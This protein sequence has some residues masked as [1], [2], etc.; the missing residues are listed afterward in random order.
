MKLGA[1]SKQMKIINNKICKLDKHTVLKKQYFA[2]REIFNKVKEEFSQL[3][4]DFLN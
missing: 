1:Y 4:A 2:F 3:E